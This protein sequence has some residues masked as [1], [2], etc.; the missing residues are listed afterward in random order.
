[1]KTISGLIL[2]LVIVGSGCSTKTGIR[3]ELHEK[4]QSFGLSEGDSYTDYRNKVDRALKKNWQELFDSKLDYPKQN[5]I[6]VE[7]IVDFHRPTDNYSDCQFSDQKTRGMLLVHGLYDSPYIMKDLANYFNKKC[8]HTRSILLPGHGTRPGSLLKIRHQDWVNI[9]NTSVNQFASQVDEVYISGFSTGGLLAVNS[10]LNQP[11]VKGIFLFA[12]ALKL[13][14]FAAKLSRL[15]G[16]KWVPFQKHDDVDYIK[17]E[18]ITL[19]SAIQVSELGDKVRKQ[20]KGVPDRIEIPV[21]IVVAENDSTIKAD[22]TINLFEKGYFGSRSEMIVY[23]PIKVGKSCANGEIVSEPVT[24]M[25]IPR[26]INSCFTHIDEASGNQY[27]I[28]DYSHMSL[29]LKST[30]E[31]YGLGD[32]ERSYK[33]CLQYFHNHALRKQCVSREI[34]SENFC[35][36]ERRTFGSV[37]YPQCVKRNMIVRRLT[38]NP[39]FKG[40]TG[41]L[42]RFISRYIDVAN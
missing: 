22:S 28:A 25:K 30:D 15:F 42:D 21:L 24:S 11:Q 12:P 18:S 34:A 1:M 41:H 10:A 19:E 8:F 27:L 6:P 23:T 35:Y 26:Y 5:T 14:G 36:G 31:H 7:N 4:Y 3:F 9:V 2:L 13:S 33:Y 32:E 40:L 38:S 29:T 16:M 17:Y 20:L 39:Q 37:K